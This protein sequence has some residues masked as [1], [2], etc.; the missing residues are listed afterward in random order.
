[1]KSLKDRNE[2]RHKE[3]EEKKKEEGVNKQWRKKGRK[4]GQL[5]TRNYEKV[6]EGLRK[7]R[8]G[9][10]GKKTNGATDRNKNEK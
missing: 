9:S 3:Q 4:K 10:K 7:I 5:V 6:K 2:K 1:M 8:K